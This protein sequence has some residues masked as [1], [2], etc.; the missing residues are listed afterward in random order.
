MLSPLILS[1]FKFPGTSSQSHAT[2]F[3]ALKRVL[4]VQYLERSALLHLDDDDD[5]R[6]HVVD[7][8]FA[9]ARQNEEFQ[10]RLCALLLVDIDVPTIN[11]SM[12]CL[13]P[14][15]LG[16]IQCTIT[17]AAQL[18]AL[19]LLDCEEFRFHGNHKAWTIGSILLHLAPLILARMETQT[20]AIDSF[21]SVNCLYRSIAIMSV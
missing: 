1:L 11:N 21:S 4:H 5:T 9:V 10:R 8:M 2:V 17:H 15:A 19:S 13:T 20:L 18:A 6:T 12:S 3:N 14:N 16:T 7:G